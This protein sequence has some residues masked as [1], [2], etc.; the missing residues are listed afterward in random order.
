MSTFVLV[1]GAWHGG[2]CW[3]RVANILRARGHAVTTPTQT[4]VGEKSH[5]LSRDITL[6]TFGEDIVNHLR[7]EELEEVVLVGHSFGGA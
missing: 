7:F 6:T 1:H 5:L 2:W 3:A 4:G